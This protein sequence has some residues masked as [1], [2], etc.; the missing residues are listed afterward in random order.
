[1]APTA[2][3]GAHFASLAAACTGAGNSTFSANGKPSDAAMFAANRRHEDHHAT[4]HQTAFN[5]SVVPWD[6]KLTAAATAHTVFP[7][8]TNAAAEAALYAAMG[9]TP[10]Q[11]ADAFMNACSAAVNAYH[12]TAAGGGVTATNSTSNADC[13]T[14]AVDSTNPS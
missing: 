4:D 8:P 12:G 9:G 1:V 3:V 10:D 6:A 2:T 11:I 5:G 13:S 14:S 7:G